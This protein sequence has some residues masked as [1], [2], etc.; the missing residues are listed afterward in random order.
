MTGKQELYK[1]SHQN[2]RD[3]R[4][5]CHNELLPV[6]ALVVAATLVGSVSAQG[7]LDLK[8]YGELREAERYQLNIADRL[9]EARKWDAALAEYEKY[10]RLYRQSVAASYVQYR[11]AQCCE[12]LRLIHRATEEYQAVV[13]FFPQSPEAPLAA[14]SIGRCREATGE[15]TQ[16]IEQYG[17]VVADYPKHPS[18]G[19]ALWNGSELALR[20][21]DKEKALT[22]RRRIVSDYPK[23]EK[24][25]DAARWLVDYYLFSEN[26]P[27][28]AREYARAIRR[29]AEAEIYL[30]DRLYETGRQYS[31]REESRPQGTEFMDQAIQLYR[32][33]LQDW[34]TT[35]HAAAASRRIVECYWHSSRP[36]Q[37]IEAARAHLERYPDDDTGHYWTGLMLEQLGQWEEARL[38]FLR[39]KDRGQG[40]LQ[41]AESYQRQGKYNGAHDAYMEIVAKHPEHARYA[42]YRLGEMHLQRTGDYAKAINAL[43][44][45]EYQ[46]PAYLFQMAE[47][48]RRWK[49]YEEC[50]DIFRQIRGFFPKDAPE[51]MWRQVMVL[52]ERNHEGDRLAAIALLKKI[53]DEHPRSSQASYAHHRLETKYG[54]SYTGGGVSK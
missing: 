45:S 8:R 37:G 30:A 40:A 7:Q 1:A 23:S 13:E 11:V 26:S 36:A 38:A 25:D 24:W 4:P 41:V 29:P 32:N 19:D 46:P 17:K 52:E 53:C 9:F 5:I 34:P 14:F 3:M 50:L 42:L 18:A 27:D 20:Q 22:L 12:N 49:K 43:R 16:A 39:Y 48:L 15:F 31:R 44:Q 28:L 6:V 51:A 54:I 33:V 21:G 2:T 35:Q 47:A 10:L